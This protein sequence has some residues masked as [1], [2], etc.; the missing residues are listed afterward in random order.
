MATDVNFGNQQYFGFD[1]RTIPGCQLWLDGSDPDVITRTGIN[2]S[3]WRDKSQNALTGTAVNSPTYQTNIQGTL[4]VVRFNGV[5]QYIDFGNVLN[6]GTN[7]LSIFAVT[8]YVTPVSGGRG[9][10]GKS[11][12]RSNPG[13]WALVHE[14]QFASGLTT[15]IEDGANSQASFSFNP[16]TQFNVMSTQNNRTSSNRIFTN[17]TVGASTSFTQAAGNLSNTDKLY[18]AAYP[19]NT[20]LNPQAGY[21]LNGDIGEII[22]Y[23]STLSDAERQQ[24]EGYLA[25]KWSLQGNLPVS[26]HAYRTFPPSMRAFRPTDI[27]GCAAWFDAMDAGFQTLSGTTVTSL[28]DK[29]GNAANVTNFYSST[30]VIQFNAINDLPALNLTSGR[31]SGAFAAGA[32]L[33]NYTHTAFLIA[34]LN[35][36]PT[37]GFPAVAFAQSATGSG[38]FF[39]VLDHATN[40]FRTV[41]FFSAVNANSVTSQTTTHFLWSSSY[42]GAANNS[43]LLTQSNG[44]TALSSTVVTRPTTTASHFFIGT[45]G[46]TN[47]QTTNTWPGLVGELVIYRVVL[48]TQERQRVEGYLA[49]KWGLTGS[50]P[51]THPFRT[52]LPSTPFDIP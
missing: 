49:R 16:S 19:D 1:P 38:V 17:G 12:Y 24:V 27:S 47:L 2:V 5:N 6:L 14:I 15:F 21:F 37:P 7:G 48:S 52:I 32:Q 29:S 40:V 18:V 10:V 23:F 33:N 30:P 3:Q 11:S 9:I 44:G 39:R 4:S 51:A 20:G 31:M 35:S 25:W 42:S 22:V 50:L 8:K 36:N 43:P 26:G 34:K 45:D 46:F 41:S 28:R 13:R